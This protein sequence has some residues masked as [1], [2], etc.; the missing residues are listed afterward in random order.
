M[1][2]LRAL[3][4]RFRG[5][6]AIGEFDAELQSHL[7]MHIEDGLRAGLPP[8]EARRQALLRMGGW[9]QTRQA[10]RERATLPWVE[11]LVQDIR[12]ALRGF[13]RNPAFTITALVTL[14]LGIGATTAVF[15]VVD[16][17]LFRSLPY[18]QDDR[19]VSFGL[20]QSLEKQ[21]FTL[22][23]F[24][25][26]WRDN[27]KPFST[28]TFERGADGCNLTENHPLQLNCA[29]V[30]GNFLSTLGVQ[31][32]LGR[33]FL[34]EEDVPNGPKVAI[35]SDGLWLSRFNRDPGVLGRNL[36]VDDH[37]YRIV[38]VLPRNFEMPRLQPADIVL[39]AQ[40]DRAEQNKAN[41]GIGVPLWAIARLKPGVSVTEAKAEMEPL[42][43]HTLQW[44]P[45]QIRNDFHLQVRSVRDRQMQGAY[46]AAWVLFAAVLAVLL[47]ACANVASLL[48]ARRAARERELAVRSALGAS[49]TRLLRQMLTEGF[50]I[51]FAG[52]ITGWGLAVFLLHVFVAMA[53]AGIPFLSQAAIDHR[54]A[55]FALAI[56]LGCAFLFGIMPAWEKPQASALTA[57]GHASGTHPRMRRVL[58][59]AQIAVSLVLL[60][61]ASLLLKSFR[62]L[63][64]QNLGMQTRNA[65][66]VQIPVTW[67]RYPTQQAYVDFY[68]RVETMLRSIPG[69]TAVGI[70]D[71]LPPDGNSWHDGQRIADIFVHGKPAAAP[72]TSGNVVLRK[73]TP[74][75]FRVLGI[76]ILLGRG[77]SEQERK[78]RGGSIILSQLL[79]ARLFPG[80]NPIG[81]H[82][83]FGTYLPR[84]A[85]DKQ[86]Y[87]VVGVAANV[88]NAGLTGQDDPEY[89][90]LRSNLPNDWNRHTVLELE[91]TLPL[92]VVS[93]WIRSRVAGIDPTVPVEMQPISEEVRRLADRPRFETALLSFFAF[94]GLV[95]A[96]IG[97]YGVLAFLAAQRTQEIGIR[98]A[99]GASRGN[100]LRLI[101]A[102]SAR[103]ISIGAVL[104]LAGSLTC[105]QW[106]R[107]LLFHVGPRD[108]WSLVAVTL[109]L[110]L[111]ALTATI[112]PARSAMKVDPMEA[113]R[114]E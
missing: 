65:L 98:M 6:R 106:L 33:N 105:A 44:I 15:S 5:G 38:G 46:A 97:L 92:S 74:D 79:A 53:P 102:E 29:S 22:G 12:Y 20:A 61:G 2:K 58:V 91:T 83:Q 32:E 21:E 23:G 63:E 95:M 64:E 104:G 50:L 70:S 86:V 90:L 37:A 59:T 24:F 30:A 51:S 26:D 113:L 40:V 112:A 76:P 108:P 114:T 36:E 69:I 78:S 77:F 99:L 8:E 35:L 111:V 47:I 107:S 18:A 73:V 4:I 87:T 66:A 100:I 56:T 52:A 28:V 9:D 3:W 41:A 31:L 19:L 60:V 103:L 101:A 43:Q 45:P 110:V 49:R 1:H 71:S 94:T 25:F 85:L 17:I 14:A 82:I 39:P 48:S 55:A 34:P 89:Y 13:R 67:G 75:Y 57:R 84:F 81:Q 109:L 7:E 10:Y 80:Q 88:K 27:Q 96:V 62:N 93:S 11:T 72:G 42:F 16:R 68:L 54:I